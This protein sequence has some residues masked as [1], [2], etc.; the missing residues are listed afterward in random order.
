MYL[1]RNFLACTR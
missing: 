1:I